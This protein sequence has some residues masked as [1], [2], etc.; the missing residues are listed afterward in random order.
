MLPLR[1]AIRLP[2]DFCGK[3][4][5][6]NLKGKV[7]LLSDNLK[8]GMVKVGTQGSDMFPLSCTVLSIQ[9][10]ITIED[11][12]VVGMG[13][14]IVS[15][16]G[17]V[18]HFGRNTII[19]A[20]NLIFCEKAIATGENFLTSWDCQIMDTDTHK[21]IDLSTKKSKPVAQNVYAG[22]NVWLGNG[23]VV[24]KGTRFAS[25]T[26]IASRSL[27]NKDYTVFGE[28]CVLAGS[29][30]KVVANNKNWQL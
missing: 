8:I 27:C 20:R 29:P 18:I 15:L 21:I 12:L 10:R 25:N 22:V 9:G 16:P 19:G 13:S 6:V 7:C 1:Q 4:R 26:I 5:F 28:N 2:F 24:N 11:R 14:S 30:A 3:V 23:V 17:S